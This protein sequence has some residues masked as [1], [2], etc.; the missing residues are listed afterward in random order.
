[1]HNM[2]RLMGQ[3]QD[4]GIYSVG[5]FKILGDNMKYKIQIALVLIL[6][7]LLTVG[8]SILDTYLKVWLVKLIL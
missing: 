8:I 7:L 2:S 3:S 1:M 5:I 6:A 4:S